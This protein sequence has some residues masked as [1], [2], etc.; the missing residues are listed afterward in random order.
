MKKILLIIASENFKD[1]EYF[2]TKEVLE[3]G[4]FYVETA[5][6]IPETAFGSDGGEARIDLTLD[7]AN[8]DNYEGVFFIGGSGALKHLDNEASYKTAKEVIDSKK[9][10]G[11]ICIA[12]IIL[13]KAGVLDGRNATVWTSLMDKSAAKILEKNGATFV[14]KPVVQD[15]KII[16]ANGPAA[17]K[18]FGKKIVKILEKEEECE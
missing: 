5:S 6:N 16:T 1:E 15:G 14:N 4:G 11:A 2:T 12:P 3:D 9:V 13:A 7:E 8:I 18:G 10:L 17:A